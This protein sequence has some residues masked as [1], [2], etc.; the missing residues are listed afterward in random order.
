[1]KLAYQIE[2]MRKRHQKRAI[3]AFAAGLAAAFAIIVALAP[4]AKA[5]DKG[6]PKKEQAFDE[7]V[8]KSAKGW[9]GIWVGAHAGYAVQTERAK[10]Q[11][12]APAPAAFD[13]TTA[14]DGL[15]YGL[16]V[17]YDQQMGKYVVAGIMTDYSWV[18]A[19]V[20]NF[21]AVGGPAGSLDV[22][23]MWFGGT[24]IGLLVTSK[25]LAYALAGYTTVYSDALLGSGLMGSNGGLTL[26]GGLEVMADSGFSL[27]LEYRWVDL[28]NDTVAWGP[29]GT[30]ANVDHN[31][32]QVRLGVSFKFDAPK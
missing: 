4:S 29:V 30:A 25:A 26:G 14:A 28:G 12:I 11:P 8:P 2:Q 24:R 20:A 23:R 1:M 18:N 5:A 27:K 9:T 21:A 7:I 3:V 17:G 10:D 15:I 22:Q 19:S 32:H 16:G 31:L 13:L 6:G